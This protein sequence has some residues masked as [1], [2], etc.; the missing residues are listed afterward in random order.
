M[1]KAFAKS[2]ILTPVVSVGST[3]TPSS[4]QS[5]G[6][7]QQMDHQSSPAM[8]GGRNSLTLNLDE[9]QMDGGDGASSAAAGV[10]VFYAGMMLRGHKGD[11]V[12]LFE[13]P[14]TERLLGDFHCAMRKRVLLQGR[15]YIF[16]HYVCF[17]SAVF[18]F[19]KKRR[20]PTRTIKAVRKRKHLGFPNSL[21]IETDEYKEFFT[22]FLSREEAYQ[23][24]MKQLQESKRQVETDD[25]SGVHGSVDRGSFPN[26]GAHSRDLNSPQSTS[27]GRAMDGGQRL[28]THG[29]SI[30]GGQLRGSGLNGER[31]LLTRHSGS[32]GDDDNDDEE[33]SGSVWV[34]EQRPAPSVA[35]G[36]RHVL[37][38][39]LLG[40]PREFFDVVLADSAPFFEDFLDSQG[41]RRI[42]LTSWK[43]HPQLGHVRDMTFTA[44]IKG[45]FGNWG[46]SHTACFQSQRF[47][48]YSDEHIVF[49]SSQTMTDIPYGDCFTVDQRWDIKKDPESDPERPMVKFD[50][51]V[52]VPFSNRCLFKSVI[53]SGSVKQVQDTYSLFVEQLRPVMQEKLLSRNILS[54]QDPGDPVPSQTPRVNSTLGSLAARS[55][56]LARSVQSMR[57]FETGELGEGPL[58]G[59][60]THQSLRN[61]GEVVSEPSVG[62]L[63]LSLGGRLVE[64]ARGVLESG[65]DVVLNLTQCRTTPQM[66]FLIALVVIMFMANTACMLGYLCHG[67]TGGS[68]ISAAGGS[69]GT[70][71]NDIAAGRP[72]LSEESGGLSDLS[73]YLSGAAGLDG[74]AGGVPT[75]DGAGPA[76]TPYWVQRMV[77]LHQEMQLLQGRMEILSREVSTVMAHLTQAAGVTAGGA[78]AAAT[79]A[80]GG[81]AG[82]EL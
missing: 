59:H 4:A 50:L 64:G 12:R 76:G 55:M 25:G 36:S 2:N 54:I 71:A 61:G 48:L 39:T 21:E 38:T 9:V 35:S 22:S 27:R 13:L 68:G 43:R 17:Y 6:F 44:P 79:S 23:L 40:T 11:L 57:A 10:P 46:V 65:V 29:S 77:M 24:I 20:V 80:G 8:E 34:M 81:R 53:E 28:G 31:S 3:L 30:I 33:D 1:L 52:R 66:R 49:E 37:Q 41:N 42:N 78:D 56:P 19:A 32:M 51:H 67:W 74:G 58:S 82:G 16:D 15:M 72:F 47:C 70:V 62:R 26:G 14:P 75:G 18:G 45:A 60:P 69:A 63:L 5:N 7:E 73:A